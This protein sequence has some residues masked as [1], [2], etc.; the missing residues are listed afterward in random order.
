MTGKGPVPFDFDGLSF[1]SVDVLSLA[2]E[3]LESE[4]AIKD[5]RT[6]RTL[7]KSNELTLVLSVLRAGQELDEHS[8]RGPVTI[9]PILGSVKFDFDGEPD[10]LSPGRVALIGKGRS[11]RVQAIE[12]AAF[13]IL[14]GLQ[15]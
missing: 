6:A 4:D 5:G 12:N 15:S 1:T 2:R 13:L 14:I 10:A 9:L 3:L 8:A 11:H 7:A